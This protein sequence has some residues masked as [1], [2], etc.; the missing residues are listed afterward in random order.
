MD[1][2]PVADNVKSFWKADVTKPDAAAGFLG[3]AGACSAYAEKLVVNG[4][5]LEPSVS[6]T[7]CFPMP[8]KQSDQTIPM[9]VTLELFGPLFHRHF[10]AVGCG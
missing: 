4:I 5:Q 3:T 8:V 1:L 7:A 6:T 10:V 2:C 9:L